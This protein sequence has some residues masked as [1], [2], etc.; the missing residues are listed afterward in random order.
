M[1]NVVP[2]VIHILLLNIMMVV[3]NELMNICIYLLIIFLDTH[4]Y[5]IL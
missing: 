2:Y 3:D 4:G 5:V 1:Y